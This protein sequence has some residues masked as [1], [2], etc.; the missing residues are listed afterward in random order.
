MEAV[1]VMPHTPKTDR[2]LWGARLL[3]RML[4]V[5]VRF[6]ERGI[7][8]NSIHARSRTPEGIRILRHMGFTEVPSTTTSRVFVIDVLTSGLPVV[9][10]YKA[11]LATWQRE[12]S[13]RIE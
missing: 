5:F 11:A 8:I 12:H 1:G 7:V 2:R 6:G 9:E 10:E 3:S 4:T 13:A